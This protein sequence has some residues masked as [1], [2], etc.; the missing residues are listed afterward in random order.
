MGTVIYNKYTEEEEPTLDIKISSPKA[1]DMSEDEEAT[2][3][4]KS[5]SD[6]EE[7]EPSEKTDQQG[8]SLRLIKDDQ[9]KNDDKE[10]K[11]STSDPDEELVKSEADGQKAL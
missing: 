4:E 11:V 2:A 8:D 9:A 1:E 5:I 10:K 7:E 6:E 3:K